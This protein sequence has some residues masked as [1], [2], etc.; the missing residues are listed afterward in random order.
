MKLIILLGLPGAGK[1]TF[2]CFLRKNLCYEQLSSDN[3]R[4][5]NFGICFN[6]YIKKE[7]LNSIFFQCKN[8]ISQEKNV[9]ID[10]TFFNILEHRLALYN[11]L[12]GKICTQDIILIWIHTPIDICIK[13]DAARAKNRCVGTTVITQLAKKFNPPTLNEKSYIIDGTKDLC[14]IW[15]SELKWMF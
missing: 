1:S 9:I 15:E 13:R 3:I 6:E 4:E 2:T 8:L 11:Y 14:Q 5:H 10:S 7:V 12:A